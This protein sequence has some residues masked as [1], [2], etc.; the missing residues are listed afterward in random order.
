MSSLELSG[1]AFLEAEQRGH[2]ETP[3]AERRLDRVRQDSGH[4]VTVRTGLWPATTAPTGSG[5]CCGADLSLAEPG[6]Y[7]ASATALVRRRV[8]PPIGLLVGL[9]AAGERMID[10]VSHLDR[11]RD[12]RRRIE[13]EDV[14]RPR[15]FRAG[16]HESSAG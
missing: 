12:L 3:R 16:R 1:R 5:V 8:F 6:M 10:G 2:V 11:D 13:A 9:S 4:L 7:F 15:Q 14:T